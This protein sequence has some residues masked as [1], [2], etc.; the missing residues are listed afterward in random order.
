MLGIAEGI[1]LGLVETEGNSDRLNDGC[2]DSLGAEENWTLGFDESE[3]CCDGDV[4]GS[5]DTL[6]FKDVLGEIEGSVEGALDGLLGSGHSMRVRIEYMQ[7]VR[8][9]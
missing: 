9:N 4:D 3:G 8:K 6:G 1:S 7:V 5:T 2:N